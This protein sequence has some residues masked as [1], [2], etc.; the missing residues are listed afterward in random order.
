MNH[1]CFR[2]EW[3]VEVDYA[4]NFVDQTFDTLEDAEARASRI[5]IND[6]Y[7]TVRVVS[8]FVSDWRGVE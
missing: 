6:P 8:R 4:G 1:L 7:A 5:G 3:K 2:Q